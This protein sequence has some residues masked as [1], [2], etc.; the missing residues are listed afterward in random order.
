MINSDNFSVDFVKFYLHYGNLFFQNPQK[1]IPMGNKKIFPEK[2][3]LKTFTSAS[4]LVYLFYNKK[5]PVIITGI[6][7]TILSY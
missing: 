1:R 6:I 2:K 3:L 7:I 4:F 5:R